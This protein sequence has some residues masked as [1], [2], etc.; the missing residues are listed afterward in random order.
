MPKL[1]PSLPSSIHSFAEAKITYNVGKPNHAGRTFTIGFKNENGED[2][3]TTVKFKELVDHFHKLSKHA[4]GKELIDT[5]VKLKK[6]N[7]DANRALGKESGWYQIK[8]G[9]HR[10]SNLFRKNH[11]VLLDKA[12]KNKT[13]EANW[14]YI[15]AKLPDYRSLSGFSRS[16]QVDK[17]EGIAKTY[18]K[19][20][21][22][23][24]DLKL[25]NKNLSG[26][27]SM[28]SFTM[29]GLSIIASYLKQKH[30]L[31]NLFVCDSLDAF[32]E[33]LK[34]ID[35]SPNDMRASFVIPLKG[36]G[37]AYKF[38]PPNQH[39]ATIGVEK[40]D[41]KLK[42]IYL[43]GQPEDVK[44]DVLKKS[45]EELKNLVDGRF[46]TAAIWCINQC[47]LKDVEIYQSMVKREY[48]AYGCETIALRDAVDFLQSHDFFDRIQSTSKKDE[49]NQVTFL[50]AQFMKPTQSR[51]ALKK[52]LKD[53]PDEDLKL[54]LEKNTAMGRDKT[55]SR[56]KQNHYVSFRSYKYHVMALEAVNTLPTDKLKEKIN[57]TFL[58]VPPT[59]MKHGVPTTLQHLYTHFWDR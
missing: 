16:A 52:Y 13:I 54:S 45:P 29:Q 4:D 34:Q 18:E 58:Q 3:T 56:R 47:E 35:E 11:D 9:F 55:G 50:P 59:K 5:Y 40:K 39:K 51:T 17:A 53:N 6:V 31:E 36:M 23:H 26:D 8:T 27:R 12:L 14:D 10:L 20:A 32:Q 38:V 57:D 46:A 49:I 41:G 21:A 43:D 19:L 2:V 28:V 22:K 15:K 25:M 30:H 24:P 1:N 48:G 42:I 44:A 33:Q 37:K 7:R